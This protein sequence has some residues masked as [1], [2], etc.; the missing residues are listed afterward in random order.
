MI[1]NMTSC[2]ALVAALGSM[3]GLFSGCGGGSGS[4]NDPAAVP[5]V[6]IVSYGPNA[7]SVWNQIATDTINVAPAATGTPEERAPNYAVDL[8]TLHVAMYDAVIAIA[9]THEP[10]A[11]TPA[12]GAAGATGAS[13]DAAASAAAYGVLKGLF[14][15]RANIYQGTYDL[16]LSTIPAGEARDR[17]IAIGA[18]VA[19]GILAKRANDGRDT[20]LGAYVPGTAPGKFRGT[21][22]VNRTTP[23]IRPFA[24]TSASQF[25]APGPPA[26]ESSAYAAD[27]N[28]T[29]AYGSATSTV[30][31][32]AQTE[33]ARFATEPPPRY[34]PRNLRQ[35][36]T[37]N[38]SLAENA[39]LSALLWVAHA[40]AITGC[41]D[42]KYYYEFWRPT[43]AIT[44]A[45]TDPNPATVA[46]P[47]W[48]PVVP[49]PN[50]PEYPAA[51]S[52]GTAAAAEILKSYFGTEKVSFSFDSAVADTVVHSYKS[53]DDAVADVQAARI[54][55]GMHFRTSTVHGAALGAAV[56]KWV[57]EHHFRPRN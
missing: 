24:L 54:H 9:G 2:C 47:A 38:K 7:V 4:S 36:A 21:N 29:K 31:T 48:V 1:R 37:S 5:P 42:S 6:S 20:V 10:Y 25:R 55:G 46:D 51:H 26:L 18:D 53:T 19:R 14:P 3:L 16:L 33:T 41:F 50:H 43:S 11:I 22:P 39:R 23:F 45:D 30:R 56:A 32:A 8:A 13:M 57:A 49:T 28:E 52:C 15:A 44:L 17:G 12:T 40:D 27:V 34:W 35:F